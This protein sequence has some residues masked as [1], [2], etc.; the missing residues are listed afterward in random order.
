LQVQVLAPGPVIVQVAFA[1]HPPLFVVH[2]LIAVHVIPL[3]VN[4]GLQAQVA[5]FAPV[6]VHCAVAAHPPLLVAHALIPVHIM[7]LPV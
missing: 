7:P 1:S 4:P 6:G 3:P 5:V 2:G